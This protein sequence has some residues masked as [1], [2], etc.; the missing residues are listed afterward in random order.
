MNP[1]F[2]LEYSTMN[3]DNVEYQKY[4]SR[5]MKYRNKG[6]YT[7]FIFIAPAILL[8]M[9]YFYFEKDILTK[10]GLLIG[11]IFLVWYIIHVLYLSS[12]NEKSITA[13]FKIN[14]EKTNTILELYNDE[15]IINNNFQHSAIKYTWI[16]EIVDIKDYIYLISFRGSA[17]II[18][19]NELDKK[20]VARFLEIIKAKL[21][22]LEV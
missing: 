15:F 1:E 22:H 10:L 14:T 2:V 7:F 19:I 18:P 9:E 13:A 5:R 16:Q 20:T 4:I 12:N 3:V 17:F 6:S 8:I 21:K 11:I